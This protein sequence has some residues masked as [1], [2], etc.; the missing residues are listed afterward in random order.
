[1]SD[2]SLNEKPG[3]K[4]EKA[5]NQKDQNP[6]ISADKKERIEIILVSIEIFCGSIFF[7]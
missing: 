1:M 5:K 6:E 2:N 4:P 3:V 7:D